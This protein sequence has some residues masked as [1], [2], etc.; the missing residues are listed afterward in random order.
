MNVLLLA[1]L[2]VTGSGLTALA[3]YAP[4]AIPPAA[5]FAAALAPLITAAAL[6]CAL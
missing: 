6:I 1:W 3:V 5:A 2:V 4:R